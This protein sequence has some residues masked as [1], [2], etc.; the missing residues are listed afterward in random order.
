MD[1]AGGGRTVTRLL[2]VVLLPWPLLVLWLA[3][4][5]GLRRW[6]PCP[7]CQNV[8]VRGDRKEPWRV[9]KIQGVVCALCK[10]RRFWIKKRRSP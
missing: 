7:W 10:G 9:L 4:R 2:A 8:L 5:Y 1:A 6:Y 3:V